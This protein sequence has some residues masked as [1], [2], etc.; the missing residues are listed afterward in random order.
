M[1]GS[2]EGEEGRISSSVS[3]SEFDQGQEVVES[4]SDSS[5]KVISE[6]GFMDGPVSEENEDDDEDD[7]Y[8]FRALNEAGEEDE[9][10]TS[11]LRESSEETTDVEGRGPVVFKTE[12]GVKRAPAMEPIDLE[13]EIEE[14]QAVEEVAD[15]CELSVQPKV[16]KAVKDYKCPICFEP[17]ENASIA[18]CGHIFCVSCLFQMVNHSRNQKK[19]GVCALCRKEIQFRQVKIVI[20]RKKRVKKGS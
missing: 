5:L 2:F 12:K 16:Y 14:Q 10:E 15:Q 6:C 17:P 19:S 18:S 3:N 7:D 11:A 9:M 13:A 20:L 4:D 1:R 8:L